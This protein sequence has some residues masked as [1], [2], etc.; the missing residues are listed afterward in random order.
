MRLI[1]MTVLPLS[2]D[3][4]I[5]RLTAVVLMLTFLFAARLNNPFESTL[6]TCQF[7]NLTGYDCPTCGL[8][9]S[10]YSFLSLK[11]S[12]SIYYNPLGC[13]LVLGLLVFMVKFTAE[14][15]TRKEILIPITI[16]FRRFMLIFILLLA[17]STWILRLC[18]KV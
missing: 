16:T 13:V 10:V 2:K 5:L 15:I 7:K 1:E 8:S 3:K 17:F 9:R 12:D 14:L 6:L 18:L 11:I 4:M